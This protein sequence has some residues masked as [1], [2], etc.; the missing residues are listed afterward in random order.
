MSITGSGHVLRPTMAAA[1]VTLSGDQNTL[2]TFGGS[3]QTLTLN[4]E[5]YDNANNSIHQTIDL[6]HQKLD[7]IK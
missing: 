2:S 1:A 4:S 6:L 3:Y 7:F 5:G